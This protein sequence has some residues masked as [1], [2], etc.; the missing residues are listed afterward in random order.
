MKKLIALIDHTLA[1]ALALFMAALLVNILWQVASRFLLNTPSS[2]TEE[3]ARFLLLWIGM[4]GGCYAYRQHSHLGLDVVVSRLP[5]ARQ[6]LLAKLVTAT[7]IAFAVLVLGYGGGYLVWLTLELEQISAAMGIPMG[8]VYSVL[9]L[10]GALIT[11][12][13]LLPHNT[14]PAEVA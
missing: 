13:A 5:P 9:P 10:S 14:T 12:Y 11:F 7:V 3:L 6:R 4:L 2:Y 1:S 8:Y